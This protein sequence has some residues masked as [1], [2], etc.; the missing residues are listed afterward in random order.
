MSLTLAFALIVFL[1]GLYYYSYFSTKNYMVEG[2]QNNNNSEKRCPN[3]LIQKDS[4]FYLY[5]TNLVE[6][7][8]VNPIMFNDLQE[9][10]E[11][12]E[13]QRAAG[14][15]CPVLYVQN[16]Y[17]AQGNRVYKVRPSVSE[18]QGGLPP[19]TPV[20]LPMKFETTPLVDATRNDPPYN[21]NGYPA[22]DQSSYYVGS[23]T[24]LDS[25]A[26]M[27]KNSEYNMLYSDNAMDP[28]WG[29]AG[30]TQA[31]VDT[32]YYKGNEVD[33]RVA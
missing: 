25:P 10:T 4:K 16:S 8:G 23:I 5:N 1:A 20:P 7:P 6:V 19:T 2:L 21:Q 3:L 17:D 28:N 30:Y 26:D 14:I 31:L 32:G 11:F 27:V 12:L 9:Y 15:R 24:P 13:W 18:P 33:I 22:Y 29:G